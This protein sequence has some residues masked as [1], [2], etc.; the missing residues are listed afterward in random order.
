[1]EDPAQ[2]LDRAWAME[3]PLRLQERYAALDR[4][5]RLLAD[6][7]ASPAAVEGRDWQLEL[8]A[9]RA[10]DHAANVRLEKAIEIA[11]QVLAQ[12]QSAGRI[13]ISRATL[14]KARAV[15]WQGTEE[16]RLAGERLL[17]QATQMFEELGH[18]EWYG[19][20]VFWRA[21]A[22]YFEAGHLI[23]SAE[24]MREALEILDA[25]SP[26]RPVVLDFYAD[27]LIELGELDQAELA[28][29]EA[30]ELA[31]RHN[32]AKGRSHVNWTRAYLVA[33]RGDA[34]SAERREVERGGGE[35][36]ET[37]IGQAFLASAA[38]LLDRLGLTEQAE[39][40][41]EKALAR[42]PGDETTMQTRALMLARTGD[43]GQALDAMQELVRGDWLDKRY[44]WRHTLLSAWATFRGGREG[45]GEL[46]ARALDQ[47]VA[48]AGS[49]NG[50]LTL[51]PE[52][53]L[54]LAPL[55]ESAGSAVAR[56]LLLDG[57][58]LI[59]R[60]F[61]LPSLTDAQGNAIELPAG[62]PGELVRMLA[63]HR[64]GLLSEVVLEAFFPDVPLDAARQRL[65][66]VLTR[67]RS[68]AGDIVSRSGE[69]LRLA[70][71]WVDL[72]EFTSAADRVR[73]ARGP[74]AV[75][76]AY[77]A[78]ALWNAQLLPSDPYAVWAEEVRVHA[79]YRHLA[80]L[81]LV[82]ADAIERGSH[83]EALTA[84][85][86]AMRA[87]PDDRRRPSQAADQQRALGRD[88]SAAYL[89]ARAG[90]GLRAGP[91]DGEPQEHTP[92]ARSPR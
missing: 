9:E 27:T 14:A 17:E 34:Y 86:A 84:L 50:A 80:L 15:A 79:E 18:R 66:Q 30:A 28:L 44:V 52:L 59:V 10:I 35:W 78:L 72:H 67:L 38:A 81:D 21:H 4:L 85:E 1:M 56:E 19:F 91:G 42:D 29:D 69:H 11:D 70:P 58:Q 60:L 2:L 63:L 5:E 73:A 49:V 43:P 23:R 31:G 20:A 24:L 89:R 48:A 12:G 7:V 33:A 45:A 13:A 54:A 25:D 22:I 16:K 90:E 62:M 65:R 6:P 88:A 51:E 74:R 3:P 92:H 47:A 68:S 46:A 39:G 57:R 76:L 82:A 26:R 75:T 40:Y 87:D 53:A 32:D 8:L 55:A 37:H 83:Q 71:A 36:F 64:N 61:G 77:S 41:L